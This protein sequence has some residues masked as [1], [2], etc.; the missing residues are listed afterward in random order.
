MGKTT[1]LS[2][3][4]VAEKLDTDAKTLRKFVR[5]TIKDAGGTIG[6]DTPGKGGRYAFEAKEVSN[7]RK[8]FRTWE[9]TEA[10]ARA[11]RAAK[12]AAEKA[13]AEANSDTEDDE[14]AEDED[15]EED[16]TDDDVED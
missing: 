3:K 12:R 2:A 4:E 11:E 1:L 9:A 16:E 14:S 8:L 13:A 5:K 10:K 15:I 7:L 6:E